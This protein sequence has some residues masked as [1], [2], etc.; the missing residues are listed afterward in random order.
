MSK[1]PLEY[2]T[3]HIWCVIPVYN[4]AES[5]HQ[6][7]CEAK[8][9][10][11]NVLVVDDGSTDADVSQ[12]LADTGVYVVTHEKNMGKGAAILTALEHVSQR[13]GRYMITMDGD[14]QHYPSDLLKFISLLQNED[15]VVMIIGCREFE[16]EDIP[17]KSRFG[18]KFANF[19][20]RVEAGVSIDDCQSGF[21]AYPVAT[22]ERLKFSGKHYDVDT[23]ILSRAAWA[24]YW[25]AL[26]GLEFL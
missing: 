1:S 8:T 5:V 7:V 4:N 20:L 13:G 12:L 9:F 3:D 6:V 16:S 11:P 25:P 21:R 15:E 26:L 19:W 17:G 23:E 10:V 2:R 14:S 18:R 24:G 22:I